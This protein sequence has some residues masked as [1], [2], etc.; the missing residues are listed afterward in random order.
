MAGR[1]IPLSG[2]FN[3]RDLGGYRGAGGRRVA[4]GLVYRADAL[5][6]LSDADIAALERLGITRVFD[7][8]SPVELEKDGVGD[9]ERACGRH[10]H[11]PLVSITL[12]PFDPTIDWKSINLLD[13]YL[14]M[15]D[16]GR[17]VIRT[18]LEE[19]SE[20]DRG[21]V[22]FH[23]SGGKDRTG[24]VAA[25]ILRTLGVSDDD[26]IADY[27]RSESYLRRVIDRYR[28]ELEQLGIDREAIDYLTS[29]SPARM[30]HTLAEWDRRWGSAE[31]YL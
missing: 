8:R 15:L 28:D 21:A 7:L 3:F 14:E 19:I 6:R 9:F 30:K 25:V 12:S 4:D 24:V 26:I 27:A 10:R 29:S 17:D 31:G 11:L 13:R 22:V 18:I 16:E 5:H 20:P 2:A 1:H 23:C